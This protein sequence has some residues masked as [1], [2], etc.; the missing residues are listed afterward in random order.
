MKAGTM[1]V[2]PPTPPS[3]EPS[4]KGKP[5][6]SIEALLILTLGGAATAVTFFNPA[7]GVAIGV[8]LAVVG[9]LVKITRPPG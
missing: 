2:T 7:L 8:G 1:T 3:D 6:I 5:L 4:A 9:L